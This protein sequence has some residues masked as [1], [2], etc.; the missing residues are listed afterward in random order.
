MHPKLLFS[1][2]I[3]VTI[4]AC[5]TLPPKITTESP[6]EIPDQWSQPAT[7]EPVLKYVDYWLDDFQDPQLHQLIEHGL[8]NSFSFDAALARLERAQATATLSGVSL[9]PSVNAN[10]RASRARRNN[11]G[12]LQITSNTNNTFSPSLDI[13]WELDLWGQARNERKAGIADF[14]VAQEVYQSAKL[15]LAASIARSWISL[16]ESKLQLELT[17]KTLESLEQNLTT[18]QENFRSGIARALEYQLAKANIA[19]TQSSYERQKRVFD[20]AQRSFQVL[21]GD[22]PDAII[23]ISDRL[24]QITTSIPIG[25][26]AEL[27]SRRP[28]VI[29]AE[30]RLAGNS[31]RIKAAKKSFI[32][33]IRLTTSG[34][35][36]TNE[37][38]EITNTDFK[39]WNIAANFTQPIFTGKRLKANLDRARANYDESLANYGQTLL[40]AFQEV[41]SLIAANQFF[42]EEVAAREFSKKENQLAAEM[43]W[44][45]YTNG[46]TTITTLLESQRRAFNSESSYLQVAA[47]RILSRINLYLALGGDF[48]GSHSDTTPIQD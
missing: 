8:E 1:A 46:L 32:P 16:I 17:E 7:S 21:I 30:R 10:F 40:R 25:L 34:G 42:A 20:A 48:T 11:T 28:D 19:N 33:N 23:S 5:S 6:V 39:I 35:I 4:S 47:Q 45:E 36:Q 38:S 3:L 37:L 18:V 43:A 24:P 29:Q 9:W 15:S 27:I 26:P 13:S 14:Q 41:E 31:E 12:G 22:Y 44:E 2:L